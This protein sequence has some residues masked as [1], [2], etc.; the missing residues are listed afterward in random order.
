MWRKV[1]R[2][3]LKTLAWAIGSLLVLLMLVIFL[4]R[5]PAVQ[6]YITHRAT[7]YI[8]GKTHT[9]VQLEKVYISFPKSIVL[10]KLYAEDIRHDTLLYLGKLK[11][12]I[13]MLALLRH[14]V[15]VNN[16]ELTAANANI[17]RNEVDSNFN[18][19][20]LIR[21]FSNDK[22]AAPKVKTVSK[23]TIGWSIG[24]DKIKL[25]DIRGSYADGVSGLTITGSVGTLRLN[26]RDID[27]RH[28]S[29][30]GHDLALADA[31]VTLTQSKSNHSVADS[32]VALL[33]LLALDKIDLKRI[34]FRYDNIPHGQS[35]V[36]HVG[37]LFVLPGA[38]DLNGHHIHVKR[39]DLSASD[40]QITLMR[41]TIN[42]TEQTSSPGD[43]IKNGWQVSGD[44]VSLHH[45]D[46]SYGLS[47]VAKQPS[48]VDFNHLDIK[49]VNIEAGKISYSPAEIIAIVHH[50]SLKEQSGFVLK[51]LSTNGRYDDKGASLQN[52]ILATEN[53]QV[54]RSNISISYPSIRA[55][56][57]DIGELGVRADLQALHVSPRDIYYFAPQLQGN[58]LP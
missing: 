17:I 50:I 5:L 33:P 1:T 44:T 31:A 48:G 28:L 29:F 25:D 49:D 40:G 41:D 32:T 37:S 34:R 57:K 2:I 43:T 26:M 38:I 35:Y 12:D 4:I 45:I 9:K 30:S 54:S 10:E 52:L 3:I 8:S 24:V 27:I 56:S 13:D 14:K 58:C 51:N 55:L 46:F 20:F 21:A 36:I 23:D 6:T 7:A 15:K 11:V 47:N 18:F 53:S 39:V 22:K 19:S 16:L 42:S